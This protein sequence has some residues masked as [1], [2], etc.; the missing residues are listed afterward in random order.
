MGLLI[1]LLCG[2]AG[3]GKD[4]LASHIKKKYNAKRFAYANK[5]KEFTKEI[6]MVLFGKDNELSELETFYN[7]KEKVYFCSA[8]KTPDDEVK[9][10]TNSVTPRKLLQTIGNKARDIL[11]PA[12]WCVPVWKEIEK[13]ARSLKFSERDIVVITDCRYKNEIEYIKKRVLE[14]PLEEVLIDLITIKLIRSTG[15]TDSDPGEQIKFN[16]D[17]TIL[18]NTDK[19]QDLYDEF[20]K[21]YTAWEELEAQYKI[22]KKHWL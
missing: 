22:D 11:D 10:T 14:Y 7:K 1:I 17:Y 5:L 19:K 21:I 13:Y 20:D 18:N 4:E 15:R 8:K 6:T 3:V 2:A 16:T 9:T 12:I